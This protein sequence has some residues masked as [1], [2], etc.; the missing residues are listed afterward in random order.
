MAKK[1]ASVNAILKMLGSSADGPSIFFKE[2]HD[3]VVL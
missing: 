1:V 3:H 2:P